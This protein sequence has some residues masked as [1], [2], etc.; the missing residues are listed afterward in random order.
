MK[1]LHWIVLILGLSIGY[2]VSYY[3]SVD[4]MNTS[5]SNTF[6]CF[7]PPPI[8]LSHQD[9]IRFSVI[10]YVIEISKYTN[11]EVRDDIFYIKLNISLFYISQK[12]V[13]SD[14]SEW[15]DEL[16]YSITMIHTIVGLYKENIYNPV[17]KN[18]I[19]LLEYIKSEITDNKFKG[20]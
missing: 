19:M 3:E 17:N 14:V 9:S 6:L 8:P 1:I 16:L 5:T 13:K 4:S 10:N 12:E 11:L 20:I 18:M 7:L 2:F 15:D